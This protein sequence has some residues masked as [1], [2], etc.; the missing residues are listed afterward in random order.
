MSEPL[1]ATQT[2][3][4]EAIRWTE[5]EGY[6]LGNLQYLTTP[7]W[8]EWIED[9]LHHRDPFP[10]PDPRQD[11]DPEFLFIDLIPQLGLA[12]RSAE[13][14]IEGLVASA[15]TRPWQAG[16]L[17]GLLYLVERL[18]VVDCGVD[19]YVYLEQHCEPQPA[20][21][22]GEADPYA[23]ALAALAALEGNRPIAEVAIW[24]KWARKNL[25]AYLPLCFS[26][27]GETDPDKAFALLEKT[28]FS[29]GEL[30]EVLLDEIEVFI[31]TSRMKR[32]W[33][34]FLWG[35]VWTIGAIAPRLVEILSGVKSIEIPERHEP[36]IS[37]LL[38]TARAHPKTETSEV[39]ESKSSFDNAAQVA[40][41]R[42]I[43]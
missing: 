40:G 1:S 20:A 38:G 42:T 43:H 22:V 6:R 28:D 39:H 12:R 35:V 37:T 13:L 8:A 23:R 16:P 21:S 15:L 3:Y 34:G 41:K 19:I 36:V 10:G 30:A 17:C 31:L 33:L 5:E 2:G 25:T 29:D 14:A 26:R 7:Q 24:R 32:K 9:R 11:E 4:T 27:L 18:R